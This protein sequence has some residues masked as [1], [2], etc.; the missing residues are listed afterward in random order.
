MIWTYF[1][2][3]FLW[4]KRAVHLYCSIIN[5]PDSCP[6][7]LR[8]LVYNK[9]YHLP[10]DRHTFIL[11]TGVHTCYSKT[12]QYK[13]IILIPANSIICNTCVLYVLLVTTK[14]D[15]KSS[16]SFKSDTELQTARGLPCSL[17]KHLFVSEASVTQNCP[18]NRKLDAK[19]QIIKVLRRWNTSC[20]VLQE[21]IS[22]C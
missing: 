22:L 6:D 12:L 9:V 21:E 10:T 16:I 1:S 4:T 8:K 15:Y 20:Q 3:E 17:L 5:A 19:A 18:K 13:D 7:A 14:R 11:N 2:F